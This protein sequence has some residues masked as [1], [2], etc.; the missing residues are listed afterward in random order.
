MNEELD[1]WAA[2]EYVF[3]DHLFYLTEPEDLNERETTM[4]MRI[5]AD[6]LKRGTI[7]DPNWYPAQVKSVEVKPS[8]GDGSTNWN[9][10]IEL[11]SGKGK[12]G[13]DYAGVIVYRLFNEKA[14]G[15][16]VPFVE[17]LGQKVGPD[18]GEFDPNFAVNKKLMVYIKNREY[19]GKLQNEVA[20]FRPVG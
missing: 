20:D 2:L 9:F 4:K 18:G 12:D 16:A 8:K 1:P 11:L 6:D 10:K 14:M 19:E 5:S 15:F 13:K 3:G 17:A 7:V